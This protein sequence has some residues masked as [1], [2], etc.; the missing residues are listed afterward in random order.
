MS[1]VSDDPPRRQR[2][3]AY[4][5]LRRGGPSGGEVL[6]ARIASHIHD[7]LWTLPGGGVDH[8]ED[9]RDAAAR[10]VHEHFTGARPDGRV[11]D[12][13]GVGLIFDAH[14]LPESDG[15]EPHV[16]EVDGTTRAIAWVPVEQARSFVS[17]LRGVSKQPV[18]Y[19]ELPGAQ[20]A[21]E[22]FPS[23]R[24]SAAAHAVE[25]FLAVVRSEHGGETPAEA[26][27]EDIVA[28]AR[29]DVTAS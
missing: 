19:A 27:D 4:V 9:P 28:A 26:V 1:D 7:D 13:H 10:E 17:M 11:E 20:H 21:F 22:I 24:A 6:L 16:V 5:V 3:A 18:A 2:L 8:G 23:I 15:V 12:F 25:R 14:V 29:G